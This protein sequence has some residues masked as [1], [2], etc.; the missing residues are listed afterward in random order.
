MLFS[1]KITLFL[2]L[3]P[4]LAITSI[5]YAVYYYS[6]DVTGMGTGFMILILL[7]SGLLFLIDR[8]A[9]RY[10]SAGWLSIVEGLLLI[11]LVLTYTYSTRTTTLDLSAN[12]S[13]YVVVLW[14]K[15]PAHAMPF[16][17]KF[18]FSKTLTASDFS[19][20]RISQDQFEQLIVIPPTAWG[21]GYFSTG[22]KLTH[23]RFASAYFYAPTQESFSKEATNRLIQEAVAN[24][25]K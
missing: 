9:V 13:R 4:L 20:I 21:N 6:R 10:V 7:A 22:V 19:V 8:L 2:I 11:G 17:Q 24:Q 25:P 23:P 15:S 5:G 12:R 16:E 1:Q 3:C 18:L 14:T